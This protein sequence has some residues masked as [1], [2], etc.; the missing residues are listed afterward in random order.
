MQ[1]RARQEG[2]GVHT[3]TC[4]DARC[5]RPK[6]GSAALGKYFGRSGHYITVIY[7]IGSRKTALFDEYG[8]RMIQDGYAVV[9]HP[10]PALQNNRQNRELSLRQLTRSLSIFRVPQNKPET[11][12]TPLFLSAHPGPFHNSPSILLFAVVC[13]NLVFAS[14]LHF[15]KHL[16][17]T[18]P[19]AKQAFPD[20]SPLSP[21]PRD[22]LSSFQWR[23]IQADGTRSHASC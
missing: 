12:Q 11:C 9:K 17:L 1:L 3:S 20:S 5:D 21:L 23:S 13:R 16:K 15:L 7:N 14:P 4:A 19:R 2:W 10:W 22:N 8:N 6:W 18:L